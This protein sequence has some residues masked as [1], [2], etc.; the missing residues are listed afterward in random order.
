MKKPLKLKE[1]LHTDRS[2]TFVGL[3]VLLYSELVTLG[4][5]IIFNLETYI[6]R[7]IL[8][9]YKMSKGHYP[10]MIFRNGDVY[11]G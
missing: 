7:Q 6:L 1:S 5:N 10:I 2:I 4:F 3:M 11:P 8:I 9:N